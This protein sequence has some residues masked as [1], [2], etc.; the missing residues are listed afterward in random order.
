MTQQ[1]NN[2]ITLGSDIDETREV[3]EFYAEQANWHPSESSPA[4]SPIEEDQGQL[5]RTLIAQTDWADVTELHNLPLR[6]TL[7]I[8]AELI[9]TVLAYK[10][11]FAFLGFLDNI[12]IND[13]AKRMSITP[14]S[15]LAARLIIKLGYVQK[16][17]PEWIEYYNTVATSTRKTKMRSAEKAFMIARRLLEIT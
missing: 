14:F 5:A 12:I 9:N 7:S 16:L 2:K 17:D 8:A 11:T 6:D 4:H 15:R 13:I 3:L 1:K 10:F